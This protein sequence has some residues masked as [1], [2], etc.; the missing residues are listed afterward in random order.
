MSII[1]ESLIKRNITWKTKLLEP[2]L[3]ESKTLL[4]FGC[5]DLS[6][7]KSLKEKNKRL[8]ITGID[9]V[10]FSKKINGITFRSYDGKILPFK[11]NSFDTV[12]AFFV[13]H[14]CDDA[15]KS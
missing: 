15:Q 6:L 3:K 10:K 9:V 12:I 2:Y 14:H 11:N 5:G 8:Q 1:P 4:D 13:F 7:A